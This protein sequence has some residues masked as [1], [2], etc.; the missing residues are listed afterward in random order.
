MKLA[1]EM[2]TDYSPVACLPPSLVVSGCD[3]QSAVPR[4][5]ELLSC[6][7][8][9]FHIVASVNFA[10]CSQLAARDDNANGSREASQFLGERPDPYAFLPVLR[11]KLKM[12]GKGK[13]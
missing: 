11:G 12:K 2:S 6:Q 9:N 4:H 10:G 5:Q 8:T 3:H 7:G 13:R 1:R